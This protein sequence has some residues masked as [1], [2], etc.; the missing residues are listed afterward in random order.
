VRWDDATTVGVRGGWG[1]ELG[2]QVWGQ[3]AVRRGPE[4]YYGGYA[5]DVDGPDFG[6]GQAVTGARTEVADGSSVFVED[7]SA[8]DTGAVRQ[9]RAVGFQLAPGEMWEVGGRYER[10]ARHPLGVPSPLRRD[11]GSLFARLLL[12][13]LRAD[14]RVELRRERGRLARGEAEAVERTQVVLSLA[15]EAVLREDLSAS[16][17]VD[18][19][20]TVGAGG[21]QG[22]LVEG[23]GALAWRPGPLLLVARYG[24]TRELVPGERAVFGDRALQVFS[25]LPAVRLGDRLTVAAGLHVGRSSLGAEGAWGWTATLRPT[26]RVVGGLEVGAEVARRSAGAGEALSALRGEVGYRVDDRLRVAAGYTLLGFSGL[27]LPG[28]APEESQRLYLRAE[29]A[30]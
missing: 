21:L 7:V 17:R 25:L 15:A 2:P 4:T 12:P 16:G 8:H 23:Y 5:V 29:V 20:R 6:A 9:A 1:P 28:P 22:R 26:V 3:A 24:L 10:G 18:F 27:G 19:A 11:V 13:R 14:G 30:Y